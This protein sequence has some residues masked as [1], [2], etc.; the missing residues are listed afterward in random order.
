MNLAV[1]SINNDVYAE[2]A[3]YTIKNNKIPYCL[4]HGYTFSGK[5]D[6]FQIPNL[7]FEKIRLLLELLKTGKYEWILWLGCDTLITNFGIR[8]EDRIDDNYHF[9]ISSDSNWPINS[10]CFLVRGSNE[11][12]GILQEIMDLYPKFSGHEYFEQAAIISLLNQDMFSKLI[13]IV[14]QKLLNAYNY[15]MYPHIP[16]MSE[17][18]DFYG[19]NGEW[20]IGDFILH[21]PGMTMENRLASAEYFS[22]FVIK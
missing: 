16:K 8:I 14:P 7:G 19:N 13:K 11:G 1:C 12:I 5:N 2:L 18:L 6:Q 3:K 17:G 21:W 20:S 4:M 15:A 9:I 10:D 22:K